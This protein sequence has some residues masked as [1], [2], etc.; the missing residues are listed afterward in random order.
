MKIKNN[1]F[2]QKVDD[3][4]LIKFYWKL[5]K[6]EKIADLVG[7]ILGSILMIIFYIYFY[8]IDNLIH[9]ISLTFFISCFISWIL[10]CW[11]MKYTF[12][13]FFRIHLDEFIKLDDEELKKIE[14]FDRALQKGQKLYLNIKTGDVFIKEKE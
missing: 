7:I 4:S 9:S 2:I 3:I 8:Y 13:R 10:I 1:S 6:L 12:L 14:I 11:I 5:I